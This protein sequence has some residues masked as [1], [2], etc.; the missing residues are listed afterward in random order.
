MKK[1]FNKELVMTIKDDE[2]FE[3]S[4][5][6]LIRRNSFIDGDV[7]VRD[8]YH[9]TGKYSSSA[10][11]YCT[12]KLKFSYKILIVFRNLINCGAYFIIQ[13]LG[14]VNFKMDVIPNGIEKYSSFNIN[15]KLVFIDS[16]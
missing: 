8:H 16:F 13:E 1:H 5:K 4:I 9:I 14:K 11:R 15:N 6:C 7:K 2:D 12:I 3:S 10:R